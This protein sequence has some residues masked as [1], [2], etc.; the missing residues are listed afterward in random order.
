MD[1]DRDIMQ[2]ILNRLFLLLTEEVVMTA[3][4]IGNVNNQAESTAITE[5][6]MVEIHDILLHD[7]RHSIIY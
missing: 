1:L 2:T 7:M 5:D 3:L 4:L 6:P